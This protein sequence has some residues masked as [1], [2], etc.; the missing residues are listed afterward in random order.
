M[1]SF[2]NQLRVR[3]FLRAGAAVLGVSCTLLLAQA[4]S[5][6][7]YSFD[8]P[9]TALASQEPPYPSVATLTL[10]QTADGVQF[11]LDVNELSPGFVDDSFV[12]RLDIVYGG[13]PLGTDAFRNDAGIPGE[14]EFE[15]NP[16]NM[17][18]G[19][20]AADAHI[21]IDFPSRPQ[22]DRFNPADTSTW[23]VLG[24]TLADFTGTSASAN[25]KPTPIFGVISVTAYSL[26][27]VQPTPSN[28]VALVPEPGTLLLLGFGL[29]GLAWTGRRP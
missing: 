10:T 17:D 6:I 29:A 2:R 26:P 25:A 18:A 20:A 27:G 4:A 16:N 11:V 13:A 3:S 9:A 28:W 5:A 8:L 15:D 19:Y 12:E 21:V 7:S 24:A 1:R 22:D 14:F 23:T